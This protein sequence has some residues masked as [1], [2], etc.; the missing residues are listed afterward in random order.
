MGEIY[1]VE[2]PTVAMPFTGERMT[3]D[4]TGQIEYEHLHRYCFARMFCRGKDVVDVASGEGYGST[5]LAQVA[6]RVTGVEVSSD[7]AAHAAA[8]YRKANLRFICG[9]ARAI[10]L[11]SGS[12]DVVVSFETLE[13]LYEH[14][15]F[16]AEIRRILRPHG[17]LIISSPDSEVYSPTGSDVN[18]FHIRELTAAE[19]KSTLAGAFPHTVFYSQRALIGSALT[20]EGASAGIV[21]FDRRSEA[22]ID[23]AAGLPRAP[24]LVGVASGS[25]L[26]APQHTLYIDVTRNAHLLTSRFGQAAMAEHDAAALHA[27]IAVQRNAIDRAEQELAAGRLQL[28]ASA[29]RERALAAELDKQTLVA[30]DLARQR[31]AA[32]FAAAEAVHDQ[33]AELRAAVAA[34]GEISVEHARQLNE[35]TTEVA[36]LHNALATAERLVEERGALLEAQKRETSELRGTVLAQEQGRKLQEK[37]TAEARERLAARE[38]GWLSRLIRILPGQGV[39]AAVRAGD[40]CARAGDW[41]RARRHYRR[42]LQQSPELLPIWVQLGHMLKAGG[43]YIGAE[44]AY[45]RALAVD[46]SVADTHLQLGHLLKL[47]R[48]WDE[49]TDAYAAALRH[50]PSL[51]EAESEIDA[52]IAVLLDL[53][54]HARDDKNWLAAARSYQH[55]LK[56]RPRLTAIWVQLGHTLK[57]QGDLPG[58]EA[59]YR[60]ALAQQPLEAD[61]YLQLG[62]L[63]K[64][65]ARRLQAADAYA[66]AIRLDPGL[67]PA[68]EALRALVGYSPS[69]TQRALLPTNG[70]APADAAHAGNGID[71]SL[72]H[73]ASPLPNGALLPATS[74][75]ADRYGALIAEATR[76]P[77][78]ARDIIWLG[79]I[80]WH[81]RIQR[82]QHLASNLADAGARVFYISLVFDVLDDR[83]RFR[84][85][86]SPYPG[87][88]EVRLRLA[89]GAADSIYQGLSEAAVA[90][91]QQALDEALLILGVRAPVVIVE[92]PTWH[93]VAFGIPGATVVCDCL[94][95]ATGFNNSPRGL[96][97]AEATMLISSDVVIAASQPLVEHIA[98][99]RPATLI[100]NAAEV[101]FFAQAYSERPVA[102]RP[103]IGYFGA[104]AEWFNIGWIEHA[105]RVKPEWEFRLIGRTDGCDIARAAKLANVSF[106]GE[107][108]YQELPALLAEFDVALIP[109]KLVELTRC[110][111]PVKL[112]EYMSAGKPVVASAMPEVVGATDLAYIADS[113][114]SFVERLEQ[115]LREDTS[116]M[117]A[118]R[119]GWAREHTWANRAEHLAA[120][121]DASFPAVSVVVLTYNNWDYT[122]ACLR[123]LREWSDYPNLEIIVVDNASTDVTRSRLRA[124]ARHDRRLRVIFNDD[125]LGFA[126]GNNIGIRAAQ[127]EYIILLNNDTYV[128]RGWVRDLIRPMLLDSQI[129][130]VGPLTNNIGNEQKIRLI[131]HSMPEMQAASRAF[132]RSRLRQTMEVDNLAFFCVAIRRAVIDKVGLL[133][134]AYG[135]GFFEDDDY[136]RRAK[137]AGYRLVI[138]DDVFVHH[139]LSV[140]FDTMGTKA[141][142]L[143]ARNRTLFE[144][145][146]G[147]WTPHQYRAEPGFG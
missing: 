117:R 107:K 39:G 106:C 89:E 19:F 115:A 59:A 139:E 103:V 55:V 84:I 90:E 61:T 1:A 42:A 97:A 24:Y 130:L 35:R 122:A 76:R 87:V 82:P 22:Y 83:G 38:Q 91:L 141:A 105:A 138:A 62:H 12:A 16:L 69:E 111:N 64:L 32:Q 114:S 100:R 77:E 135:I 120:V 132:L 2:Q 127:G 71:H 85:I 74:A 14:H 124:L 45:R 144:E 86:E 121:I 15:E 119:Q 75:P 129:G 47:R 142:E 56:H 18:P 13:H 27:E 58:A 4:A 109:F 137:S 104:I 143:M 41:A 67:S 33:I 26:P 49:A 79:V 63:L 81:F 72:N 126:A 29:A 51:R 80:D 9:D 65:Q 30:A 131:Y 78:D 112:Y 98:P 66:T 40:R 37:I 68:Q 118:L 70:H 108:P 17:L 136:C 110:T 125:N 145:R 123:S 23:A 21:T 31:N 133:E 54:D 93:Q 101:E 99:K 50:D 147:A 96:A 25:P 128:T 34:A 57:E 48:R 28:E 5:L 146:W 3:S 46:D 52:A 53:G 113:P 94:D 43:D 8:A 95:L 92:Y 6:T 116:A 10:P 88:F 140:S 44:S 73:S 20:V 7:T 36:Q 102:S 11:A 134:E 60:S